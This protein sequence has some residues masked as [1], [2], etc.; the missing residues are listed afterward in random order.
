VTPR[1][2]RLLAA[3]RFIASMRDIYRNRAPESVIDQMT[4]VARETV[5]RETSERRQLLSIMKGSAK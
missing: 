1:E 4:Q 5:T 3:L 2:R